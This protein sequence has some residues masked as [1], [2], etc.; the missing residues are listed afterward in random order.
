[1][2]PKV[3]KE[4][5]LEKVSSAEVTFDNPDWFFGNCPATRFRR[6]IA[7]TLSLRYNTSAY[8]GP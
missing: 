4:P 2:P 5:T 3:A 6:P 1:M 7:P 8:L